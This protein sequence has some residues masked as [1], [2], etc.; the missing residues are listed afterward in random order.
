M[1]PASR[2]DIRV[3]VEVLCEPIVMPVPH[4]STDW[5]AA[6][7]VITR[8]R[9]LGL[10]LALFDNGGEKGYQAEF[11]VWKGGNLQTSHVAISQTPQEAI[12]RAAPTA[13]KK[14]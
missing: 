12:C 14:L 10:A 9:E 1:N 3:H 13:I 8:M 4:Y 2:L 5:D 6:G 7:K 11:E